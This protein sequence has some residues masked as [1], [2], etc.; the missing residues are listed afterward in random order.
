MSTC[1]ALLERWK[2]KERGVF[3]KGA[4]YVPAYSQHIDGVGNC[5][6]ASL[7]LKKEIH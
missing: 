1:K 7:L 4:L 3:S 5:V 2:E 6:C